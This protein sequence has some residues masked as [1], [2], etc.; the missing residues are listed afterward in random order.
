MSGNSN[1][2]SL[3]LDNS[4]LHGALTTSLLDAQMLSVTSSAGKATRPG[5]NFTTDRNGGMGKKGVTRGEDLY[6]DP[7]GSEVSKHMINEEPKTI[8]ETFEDI[9]LDLEETVSRVSF[10]VQKALETPVYSKRRL[11][12]LC[13]LYI[14]AGNRTY[15]SI[16]LLW[17]MNYEVLSFH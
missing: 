11:I 16:F 1:S 10:V 7:E 3:N 9:A 13:I 14:F 5:G 4:S 15:Y 6:S 8:L 17:Y 12:F 2:Q